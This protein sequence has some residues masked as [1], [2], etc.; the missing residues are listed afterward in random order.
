MNT[1][2]MINIIEYAL[3][4]S[5]AYSEAFDGFARSFSGSGLLTSD[6]GLVITMEDGSEFQITV[7]KSK[8]AK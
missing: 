2:H 1:Q 3:T 5:E 8:E 6:Q 4:Y 7:T